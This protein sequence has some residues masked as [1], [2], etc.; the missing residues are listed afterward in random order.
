MAKNETK[1]LRP[2]EISNDVSTFS[3]LKTVGGYI[4]A[5]PLLTVAKIQ[6]I[7]DTMVTLQAQEVQAEAA[8]K[9]AR[10]KA[11]VAEWNFHNASL[12][13]KD[14]VRAQFGADSN[15]LQALGLKK[16]SEYKAPK[17]KKP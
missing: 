1:R 16:A 17:K 15:E 13:G 11:V 14:Q 9:T 2:I 6:P 10:D 8:F 4:P 7:Y 12:G 5:N 3:A